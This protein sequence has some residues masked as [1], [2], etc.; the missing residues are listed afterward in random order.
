MRAHVTESLAETTQARER[1]FLARAVEIAMLIEPRGEPHHLAKAVNDR[2]LA[3]LS[4]R[5]HHMEAIRAQID[6]RQDVG[7][8]RSGRF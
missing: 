8:V 4:S 5:H 2:W 3:E 6:R 7:G 1:S